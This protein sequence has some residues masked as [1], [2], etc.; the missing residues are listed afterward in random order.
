M[1]RS[2]D[3]D[4]FLSYSSKDYETVHALAERLKKDGLRVWLDNWVIQ[5]GDLIPLKIQH[6][7]EKS[8]TLL[9]CMSPAYFDSVWGTLEHYTLLFHDPTNIQHSFLPVL[10]EDCTLPNV[11]AQFARIDFRMRSDEAY[12]KILA[13]CQSEK[14]N[15]KQNKRRSDI[16]KTTEYHALMPQTFHELRV[17]IG[18][19]YGVNSVALTPDSKTIISGTLGD[20][21]IWDLATC[22]C[23]ATIKANASFS[24]FEDV[25]I[26]PDGKM[27]ISALFD[28]NLK[29]WD[30]ATCQCF[31]TLKGHK[32]AVFCVAVTPDGKTAISGSMDKTLKV[33]DLITGQCRSTFKGHS[34][35]WPSGWIWDVAIT[36]DGK[37]VISASKDKTLKVWNL[38]TGQCQATFEGHTDEVRCVAITP[39]GKTVI[40]GSKDKTL[41]IWDLKTGQCRSTL[42]AHSKEVLSVVVTPDGKNVV[43]C[44][45]DKTIKVW[46]LENKELQTVYVG[47]ND[48]I[49]DMAITPDGKILISASFD[50]T[51]RFWYL[52]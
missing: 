19:E 48:S 33:W 35:C 28:N 7:L 23:R 22:Q 40:S 12:D 30:L 38:K 17:L 18:H 52:P 21:K 34:E 10:I 26:T 2:F 27:A 15:E 29:I 4:V 6:G 39:D 1:S 43:S 49:R 20:M 45:S 36:P 37:T 32:S 41:K 46:D 9:M 50:K 5:P 31:T 24:G 42:V 25:T 8:R 11:I 3:Y 16:V 14:Q 44:S 13:T 51:L 47:H